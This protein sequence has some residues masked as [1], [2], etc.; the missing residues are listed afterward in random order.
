LWN[1]DFLNSTFAKNPRSEIRNSKWSPMSNTNETDHETL[2]PSMDPAAGDGT[3]EPPTDFIGIVKRLGPG[4]IIAGSIVGSGELIATTK[5]G[6][7]A[8]ITLLWLVIIGCLIKVFVQIELGRY[9]INHG[10]TTLAALNRVPG[11][12]L[13]VNWIVWYW[14]IMVLVGLGQLGGIVGG[15]G[16]ALALGFPMTGDYAHA[17][18][19]PSENELKRYIA[20]SDDIENG[21]V[22]FAKL[23]E[24]DKERINQ[25]L[26][27]LKKKLE[28]LD[29]EESQRG[30]VA[31]AIVRKLIEVE[32]RQAE[33]KESGADAA[34]LDAAKTSVEEEEAVVNKLLAPLTWDDKY[35]AI[36]VTLITIAVLYRGQYN[37]IQTISTG[38]VVTFTFVTI[39]NVISLQLKPEF[40]LSA[41]EIISGLWF[42]LPETLPAPPG[43][44]GWEIKRPLATALFTFGIIGVGASELVMYPYW[45]LEKGYAKFTGVRSD[46]EG[47]ANRAR[48]WMKVMRYDAFLSMVIYTVATLAFFVM[49]V[50]VLYKQG[51][52]PDGTRMV[53]TL[54]EQYVPVFG[55]FAQWL[56]LFGAVS[57]LYSTFLVAN[58]G[59]ARVYADALKVFGVMTLPSKKTHQQAVS[60]F[61]V[62]LPSI[63]LGVFCTG[64][65]VVELVL[66][67]GFMQAIM[68]PMLG[69]AALYFRF[70]MVDS[71]VKPGGLWDAFLIIS[72]IGLLIA[73][74]WGAYSKIF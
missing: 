37:L 65:N 60:A 29:E 36:F 23:N 73:G 17:I 50:A 32:R 49:G 71:R 44:V 18:Q 21:G 30:T 45:C 24:D 16:Q 34:T 8:G 68:L 6:A 2:P 62:I 7:Q 54:M 20:W 13:R 28:K 74:T 1:S 19:V 11:P 27:G 39:G 43:I 64:F 61:C 41:S 46:D 56:F 63:S 4:L 35:W 10:E 22:E 58:A 66:L 12:R 14:L 72:C 5:T 48:G 53:S 69:F 26:K 42:Q 67:G 57:V 38:L 31:V 3:V 9:T 33:L 51:L 25:G 15:V 55:E 70:R 52:D 47:W 40:Q 59:L